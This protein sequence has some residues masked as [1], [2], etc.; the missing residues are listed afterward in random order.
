M[1]ASHGTSDLVL[2]LWVADGACGAVEQQVAQEQKQVT[3]SQAESN[4]NEF[5]T[6]A[7][8]AKDLGIQPHVLR[9]SCE[10][11]K[12]LASAGPDS[13]PQMLTLIAT[14]TTRLIDRLLER[15]RARASSATI[16][17]YGGAMHNDYPPREGR[18]SYSFGPALQQATAG[19]YVE[20]DMFV[21]EY[22]KDT[23]AWRSL[24]WYAHF[25][26][27]THSDKAVLLQ[28]S[29]GSYVLFFP[30]SK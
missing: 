15:N 17:A 7:R 4:Q 16:V 21:R 3:A 18:E 10:D 25:D 20:L 27:A 22:V 30:A 11:Y 14:Y 12:T 29:Q 13:V 5:V 6:L 2:E 8:R 1:L 19:Q 24:P 23:E 9:P 26:T 28:P